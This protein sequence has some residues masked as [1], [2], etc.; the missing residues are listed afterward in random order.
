MYI[1]YA[2]TV[3]IYIHKHNIKY[4]YIAMHILQEYRNKIESGETKFRYSWFNFAKL[5]VETFFSSSPTFEVK[6]K[7]MYLTKYVSFH[8]NCGLDLGNWSCTYKNWN[9]IL[10]LII[11]ATLEHCPDTV[12][13]M[14][15]DN[16]VCFYRWLFVNPQ[17]NRYY[18]AT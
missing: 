6:S 2:Y 17:K 5:K 15:I 13:N 11:I 8:S 12:I 9:S 10:L 16:Q 3:V 18:G 4:V 7:F 14:A 1:N